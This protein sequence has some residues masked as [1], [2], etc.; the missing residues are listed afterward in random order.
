[1]K[2]SL[3][4]TARLL[5]AAVSALSFASSANA[6][7]AEAAQAA[8]QGAMSVAMVS[9]VTGDALAV[10]CFAPQP[11]KA[12]CI[13]M[14]MAVA[15][16]GMALMAKGGAKDSY[17]KLS[18]SY[19]PAF[20]ANG[21]PISSGTTTLGGVNGGNGTDGGSLGLNGSTS[22]L[23]GEITALEKKY[24]KLKESVTKAGITVS[25]DG[26]IAT[27]KDGKKVSSSAFANA[28]AMKNAGFG[29]SDIAGI[30]S[31]MADAKLKAADRLKGLA[32]MMNDAGGGGGRA[33]GGDEGGGGYGGGGGGSFADGAG[34]L[35][36]SNTKGPNLA[37]MSKK[38]GEDNIGVAGDNIFEMITRRY[39]ARDKADN[40]LKDK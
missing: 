3:R 25:E 15:Q 23:G 7:G 5:V 34:K 35:G 6:G 30:D 22:L 39:Q 38:F 29:A 19:N 33:A 12:A 37:G 11:N 27:T 36:K 40:F 21:N 2:S 9:A 16:V 14:A 18:S 26:K 4:K 24:D 10:P 32:S 20:D 28:Q 31:A 1:M 17:D 8:V 13:M